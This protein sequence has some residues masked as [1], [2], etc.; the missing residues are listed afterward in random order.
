MVYIYRFGVG[1][2]LAGYEMIAVTKA[3]Q[4]AP[5]LISM[6]CLHNNTSYTSLLCRSDCEFVLKSNTGICMVIGFI[7]ILVY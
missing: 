3:N 5:M 7:R 4:K 2:L 1:V 6:G